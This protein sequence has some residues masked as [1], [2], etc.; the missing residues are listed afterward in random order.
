[1]L[2]VERRMN[3]SHK[4]YF[5]HETKVQYEN[6]EEEED[7]YYGIRCIATRL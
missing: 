6:T 3:V 2:N 7:K 4:I 5:I 1:M